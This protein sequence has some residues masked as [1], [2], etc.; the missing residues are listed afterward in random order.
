MPPCLLDTDILSEIL[1]GRDRSVT[2]HADAYLQR[3][4]RFTISAFTAYE[5]RRG[6][7]WRGATAKL[8]AFDQLLPTFEIFP[9]TSKVLGKAAE[10]W[11]LAAT[12]GNPKMD[13]DLVIA[14]TAIVHQRQLVTGNTPHFE[15]IDELSV[16]SWRAGR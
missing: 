7:L 2:A 5:V 3:R 13:A 4:R 11:S 1:K 6:L 10:L 16:E 8:A 12:N 14:A 15:W 9:V